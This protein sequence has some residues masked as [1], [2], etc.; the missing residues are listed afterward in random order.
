M[1]TTTQKAK[2]TGL[3]YDED[4]GGIDLSGCPSLRPLA[5]QDWLDPRFAPMDTSGQGH[6]SNAL[7]KFLAEQTAANE[8]PTIVIASGNKFRIT[9]H[10]GAYHGEGMI[11]GTRHRFSANDRETLLGKIGQA[12]KPQNAYRALTKDEE[13]QVI[14]ACQSGD[15]LTGIG[16]Y[17]A[18][19]IGEARASKYNS[20]IEM[21][22]DPTLVP[23]MDKCADFCWFHCRPNAID[24]PEWHNYKNRILAGRPATF[25]LLDS[26][27][28]RF[29]ERQEEE[30]QSALRRRSEAPAEPEET[31]RQAPEKL[32][33]LDDNE[34]DDLMQS[35]RQQFAREVRAGRR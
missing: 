24:T 10:N 34:V 2:I 9:Y 30:S 13:L 27:W 20:P 23:I 21:M 12:A 11:D 3:G 17:L 6:G 32:N 7:K 26:I 5:S 29:D 28:L 15:K 33:A 22:Y 25:D 35:T 14:R 8:E 4:F 31:P 19:S 1:I 18:F 16:L